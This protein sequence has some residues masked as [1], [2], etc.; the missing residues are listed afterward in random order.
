MFYA[1]KKKTLTF[2]LFFQLQKLVKLIDVENIL[3]ILIEV[4]ISGQLFVHVFLFYN[5]FSNLQFRKKY[6][7]Q[8]DTNSS[9]VTTIG[10]KVP[11]HV[12]STTN[13]R[14]KDLF[15]YCYLR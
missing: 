9:L 3:A 15:Y 2:L 8:L 1:I 4:L 12:Q 11:K 13:S 10:C 14:P 7:R 6:N 5:F